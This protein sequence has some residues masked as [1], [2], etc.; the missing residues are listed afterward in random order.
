MMIKFLK[1]LLFTLIAGIGFAQ[2]EGLK[3]VEVQIGDGEDYK[4]LPAG[5]EGLIVLYNTSE[6]EHKSEVWSFSFLDDNF[7]EKWGKQVSLP[8]K[9][10]YHSY[11]VKEK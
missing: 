1:V 11:V 6:R 10:S 2:S 9:L 8:K 5:K 7:S 4:V 3:R